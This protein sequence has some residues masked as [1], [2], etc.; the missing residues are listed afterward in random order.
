MEWKCQTKFK[1]KYNVNIQTCGL[2]IE[3]DLPYLALSPDN[4]FLNYLFVF[5]SYK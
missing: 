3:T 4:Y 2:I 1:E 5:Y